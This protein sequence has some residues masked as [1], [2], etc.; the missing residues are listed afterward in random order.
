VLLPLSDIGP[1]KNVALYVGVGA[2]VAAVL[3][4]GIVLAVV[5]ARGGSCRDGLG[6]AQP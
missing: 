3:A 5:L 6:C 4:G 2:A 1:G